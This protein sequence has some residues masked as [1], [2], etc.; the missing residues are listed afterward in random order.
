VIPAP[1]RT[2]LAD[3][4]DCLRSV[5]LD[6]STVEHHDSAL[7]ARVRDIRR[8]A[9]KCAF[10]RGRVLTQTATQMSCPTIAYPEVIERMVG[11]WGL[12]PQTSTVSI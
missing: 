12:E 3:C 2:S 1:D 9:L 11:P 4:L 10:W 8:S 6:V 5:D 7:M